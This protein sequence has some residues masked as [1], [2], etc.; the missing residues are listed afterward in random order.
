[1]GQLDE[2]TIPLSKAS[3]AYLDIKLLLRYVNNVKY[4]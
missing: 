4:S 3:K 1:M 2:Y